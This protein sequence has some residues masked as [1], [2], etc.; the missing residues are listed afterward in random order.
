MTIDLIPEAEVVVMTLA[1]LA[2]VLLKCCDGD[3]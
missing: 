2:F 1:L 3:Y